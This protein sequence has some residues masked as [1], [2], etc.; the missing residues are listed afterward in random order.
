MS[1]VSAEETTIRGYDGRIA[2]GY[3]LKSELDKGNRAAHRAQVLDLTARL[4]PEPELIVDIGCGTGFFTS[5]LLDA[6]P[7][8]RA[9]CID[10]SQDM[11][12]V[13]RTQLAP[14]GRAQ[15]V[16]SRFEQI[17]WSD[18]HGGVDVVFSA[19]AIHHLEHEQKWRLF[20][21]I[22]DALAPR[23]LFIMIDQFAPADRESMDLLEYLAC[24]D[25]QRRVAGSLGM[26]PHAVDLD[27]DTLIE[28]DRRMRAF[29]GDKD[30]PLDEQLLR[31]RSA[32]FA[33]VLQFMQETRYFGCVAQKAFA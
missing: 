4:R 20:E 26:S 32:G 18:F 23:G 10:G 13:A 31:I 30:A 25:I 14:T 7:Q 21:R 9:V 2:R 29:E 16:H 28:N 12:S 27:I 19:L 8:A 1:R 11:L 6:F 24:R 3:D 5:A 17:D 15:F 33:L 22:H